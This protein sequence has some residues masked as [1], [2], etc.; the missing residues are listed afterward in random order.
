MPD[1]GPSRQAEQHGGAGRAIL[2]AP[3]AGPARAAQRPGFMVMQTQPPQR[4]GGMKHIFKPGL[5][6]QVRSES[7]Q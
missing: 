7:G 4:V 5:C 1:C 6:L 3:S 2:K